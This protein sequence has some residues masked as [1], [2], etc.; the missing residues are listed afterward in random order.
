MSLQQRL[1]LSISIALIATLLFGSALA[2]WHAAL[3]V[4]TE[5]QAAIAVGEHVV[6]NAIEDARRGDR[7]RNPERL[8]A[9]FNGD[10]HVRAVLI[11][12]DGRELLT[13]NLEAP[14]H[15]VP[16]WFKRYL[17]G[18]P[19][20]VR[21]E[22][23]SETNRHAA[24]VLTSDASNELAEAWSDIGVSL[25]VLAIFSTLVLVLVYWILERGLRPLKE[26]GEAFVRIGAGDY[27]TRVAEGGATELAHLAHSFNQ[28]TSQL[29]TMKA[30]NDQLNEQLE[31]VQEE[32]RADIARELHDEI[33]P[34]LF[35]VSLDVSAMQRVAKGRAAAELAPR[36]DAVRDAIAHMQRHLKSILGRLRPTVLLDLGLAH[37]V[38]SL[39]DFW[40]VRHPHIDFG[41][42]IDQESFGRVL[43]D[44]IYRIV[45]EALSNA[46]RHGTPDHIGIAV[47]QQSE[48]IITVEIVD[49]GGGLSSPEPIAGF[50][51][52]GMQER[53]ALLGGTL[54]VGNRPGGGGVIVAARFPRRT[55]GYVTPEDAVEELSA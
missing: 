45:R 55:P 19:E 43:D 20:Q 30:Q 10:R 25:I 38:E 29:S 15:R 4:Q 47:R 31:S 44:A 36:I 37:A 14:D 2:F 6:K 24:I 49:N 21:V 7:R 39:V 8:I 18:I 35:A 22:L 42:D 11:D 40:K 51:I 41:V 23:P 26:L 33:G 17:G 50:G 34:F 54:V 13:S 27:T 53:V 52:T 12:E 1:V 46:L 5:L 32:E 28:M 48:D 16:G 3:K 9:E